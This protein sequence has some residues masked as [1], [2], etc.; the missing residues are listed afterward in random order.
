MLGKL[1][2]LSYIA[3]DDCDGSTAKAEKVGAT[4]CVPPSDIPNIGRFSVMT[5][6]SGAMI[7]PFRSK[8][9]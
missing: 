1:C 8:H 6:P 3:V 7:A 2:L 4:I 5:D 9:G